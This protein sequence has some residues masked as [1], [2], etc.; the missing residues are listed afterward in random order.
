MYIVD[1]YMLKSDNAME[2]NTPSYIYILYCI[3]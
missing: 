3:E 1:T 2:Y